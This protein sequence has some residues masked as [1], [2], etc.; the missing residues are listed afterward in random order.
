MSDKVI[1]YVFATFSVIAVGMMF[2]IAIDKA[3]ALPD[4]KF[5]YSTQEC[6]EVV[7]Y[8]D[9]AYTCDNMP[10]RYYHQWVE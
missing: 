4:V 5:S 2:V 6:V 10:P 3:A 1:Q 7:N 8:V 9:T